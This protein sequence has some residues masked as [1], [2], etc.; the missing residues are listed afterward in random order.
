M[1]QKGGLFLKNP[2]CILNFSC[3]CL[4]WLLFALAGVSEG[5]SL[6]GLPVTD[7]LLLRSV[8]LGEAAGVSERAAAVTTQLN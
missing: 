2:S 4:T 5:S 1:P 7:G 8:C 6:C 3:P